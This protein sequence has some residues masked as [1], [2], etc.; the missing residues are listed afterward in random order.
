ML[1][2]CLSVVAAA[3]KT[4]GFGLPDGELGL[5]VC[6]PSRGT[7]NPASLAPE[8]SALGPVRR[9]LDIRVWP[10]LTR[11]RLRSL[12]PEGGGD[13]GRGPL[14]LCAPRRGHRVRSETTLECGSVPF[15]VSGVPLGR[16]RPL[17][18]LG[19]VALARLKAGSSLTVLARPTLPAVLSLPL[20]F[21]CDRCGE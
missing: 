6:W 11:C 15:C 3:A 18:V 17:A 12:A 7:W 5:W 1:T 20:P 16:C 4:R 14:P 8:L 21:H 19:V 2:R 10:P 9:L 13:G